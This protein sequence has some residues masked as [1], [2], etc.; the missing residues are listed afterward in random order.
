MNR[1]VVVSFIKMFK[2]VF[3]IVKFYILMKHECYHVGKVCNVLA[4][5]AMESE[6]DL[7]ELK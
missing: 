3:W 4:E 2:Y 1:Q 7:C 5:R 6:K